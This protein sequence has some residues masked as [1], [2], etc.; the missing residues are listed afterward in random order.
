VLGNDFGNRAAL[1]TGAG[2]GIGAAIAR[3]LAIHGAAVAINDVNESTARAVANELQ[4]QGSRAIAVPCDVASKPQVDAM[5]GRVEEEL[6]PLWLV[7]NN[8]GVFHA[9]PTADLE[10]AAWDQDFAIDAKGV[11]LCCQAAIKR[12]IPRRAGRIVNVASI[13]GLIVRTGQIGY[14]SAKAAT[15]H[16]S[17]CLAVEMAPFGITVNC[18]CPGMTETEML[19]TSVRERGHSLKSYEALIPGGHMARA[20]DHARLIAFL[21]TEAAAHIT[22]QVISVDGGQ[23]LNLPLASP[24]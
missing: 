7:V 24:S 23:S 11:F 10:E 9:A 15:I 8:A 21:A 6:G 16:F 13:A 19:L 5:V 4:S 18:V 3:T 22:G 14:C 1:V 20:E 2:R 17:R 12:M